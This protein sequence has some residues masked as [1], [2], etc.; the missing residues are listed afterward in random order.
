M[1]AG[2]LKITPD[3][4]D[5]YRSLGPSRSYQKVAE[6]YGATKKAVS[7][8]ATKEGWRRRLHL[9]RPID[10]LSDIERDSLET[11]RIALLETSN[12]LIDIARLLSE[13]GTRV[14]K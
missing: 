10:R 12:R 4:F 6:H 9:R 11:I 5:Y 8:H 1:M 7:D 3:A 13:I 14:P 2:R